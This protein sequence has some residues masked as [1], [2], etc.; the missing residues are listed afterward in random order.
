MIAAMALIMPLA[1]LAQTQSKT[2]IVNLAG[3]ESIEC[4]S[5]AESEDGR[6]FFMPVN[7]EPLALSA[8]DVVAIA[9]KDG[10]VVYPKGNDA[11]SSEQEVLALIEAPAQTEP[12]VQSGSVP[13]QLVLEEFSDRTT[14]ESLPIATDGTP[15]YIVRLESGVLVECTEF[16]KDKDYLRV[17]TCDGNRYTYILGDVK[18]ITSV[19]TSAT[20]SDPKLFDMRY[21][22]SIAGSTSSSSVYNLNANA[23]LYRK[24]Y[25]DPFLAGLLSFFIPGLGQFYVGATGPGV[26]FMVG[27]VILNS[28]WLNTD[29]E[30]VFVLALA[31]ALALN[32]WSICHAA[33]YARNSNRVNGYYL[34]DGMYL[35]IQPAV[36]Y[37]NTM[38]NSSK[39]NYGMSLT[40]SF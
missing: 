23:P 32:I 33:S 16:S 7:G 19:K 11:G 28:L 6:F 26:G 10:P 35:N 4:V 22:D 20:I 17:L 9:E 2:F 39:Y 14:A 34:G 27:N 38:T 18:T 1:A 25:K 12:E 8:A 40:L 31:G 5:Y 3:G 36:T 15:K 30:D 29:R 21:V 13:E 24:P 37:V